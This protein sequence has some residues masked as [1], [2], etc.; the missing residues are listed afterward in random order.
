[1]TCMSN[2]IINDASRTPRGGAEFRVQKIG[3]S[4]VKWVLELV[5]I[6]A[7]GREYLLSSTA[8]HVRLSWLRWAHFV[9]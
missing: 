5:T 1:M 4:G 8:R 6:A 9:T 3:S 7:N 2:D